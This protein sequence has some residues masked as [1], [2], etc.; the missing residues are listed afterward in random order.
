MTSDETITE[1]RVRGSLDRAA[2]D[3]LVV[4]L[5]RSGW[6]SVEARRPKFG[7]NEIVLILSASAVALPAVLKSIPDVLT[8]WNARDRLRQM[9]ITLSVGD[10]DPV[11]LAVAAT[12]DAE[13]FALLAESIGEALRDPRTTSAAVEEEA[14]S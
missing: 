9:D 6:S 10:S 3:A 12:G 4:L 14:A 8:A 13:S 1:V 11:Q 2:I 5:E 7:A